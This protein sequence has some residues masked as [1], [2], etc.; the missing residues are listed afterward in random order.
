MNAAIRNVALGVVAALALAVPA[1]QGQAAVVYATDVDSYT[2]G[3]NVTPDRAKPELALGEA[4]GKFL[5]LG[6]GGS[7]VFEFGTKFNAPA[8]LF[9]I[10][11]GSRVRNLES[12]DVYGIFDGMTTLLGSLSNTGTGAFS[13]AGVFTQLLVVDTTTSGSGDGYE[14]DAV[15]VTPAAIPLPAGGLLLLSALGGALVL[16]R[17]RA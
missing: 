9:E 5:S 13:F 2:P 8:T 15:N 12:V 7:A 3:A 11:F 4:D 16:T 6:L 1:S 17:R 10:T 14:I